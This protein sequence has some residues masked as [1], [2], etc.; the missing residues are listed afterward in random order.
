[1]VLNLCTKSNA[2]YPI[3][4][5]GAG[6]KQME[7]LDGKWPE[8]GL[9]STR[10]TSDP[11]PRTQ[12]LHNTATMLCSSYTLLTEVNALLGHFSPE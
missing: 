8:R 7:K 11:E 2:R 12:S 10:G 4:A 6:G 3:T 1:M 5:G 9:K